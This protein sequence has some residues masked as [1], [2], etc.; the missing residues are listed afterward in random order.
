ML[1]LIVFNVAVSMYRIHNQRHLVPYRSFLDGS[2]QK[3][4]R[5]E[6]DLP[7]TTLVTIVGSLQSSDD[8][9]SGQENENPLQANDDY[10]FRKE[11]KT[12]A[13]GQAATRRRLSSTFNE[14]FHSNGG[15]KVTTADVIRPVATVAGST[16]DITTSNDKASPSMRRIPEYNSDGERSGALLSTEDMINVAWGNDINN[17][18]IPLTPLHEDELEAD[19]NACVKDGDPPNSQSKKKKAGEGGCK[20]CNCKKSRCLKLYCEC[21][22]AGIYC[23]GCNCQV[24]TKTKILH[25]NSLNVQIHPANAFLIYKIDSSCYLTMILTLFPSCPF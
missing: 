22:A 16:F 15:E 14:A 21:F 18:P 17:T 10:E 8:H 23:E 5:P 2:A 12:T 19:E 13:N 25:N 9:T 3:R 7:R 11:G 20:K 24:S 1:I 4:P 6:Q